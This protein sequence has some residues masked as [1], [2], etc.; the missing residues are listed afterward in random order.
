MGKDYKVLENS[1]LSVMYHQ[2]RFCSNTTVIAFQD[3]NGTVQ[4]GN[5]TAGW[6]L[7]R[8]E[9]N[10]QLP[11]V[12]ALQSHFISGLKDQINLYHQIFDLNMALASRRPDLVARGGESN[13]THICPCQ[14]PLTGLSV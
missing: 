6:T 1:D 5:R 12:L 11:T 9:F 10:P 8:L 2:C 7:T 3:Q 4:I 14:T 13:L